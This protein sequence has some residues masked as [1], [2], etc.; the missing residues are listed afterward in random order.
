MVDLAELYPEPKRFMPERFAA[1]APRKYSPYE[2]LPFGAS[3]RLCLGMPMAILE[4]KTIIALAVQKYRLD[5][6]PEQP[7]NVLFRGTLLPREGIRMRVNPQDR[8]TELSAAP[9]TGTLADL[10]DVPAAVPAAR[11][12]VAAEQP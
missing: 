1:D 4:M 11:E 10:V 3:T 2:Y 9:I 7:I 8:R 5:L 6:V 12:V